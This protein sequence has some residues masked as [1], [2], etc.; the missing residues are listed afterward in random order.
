MSA[1]FKRTL[2]NTFRTG[3]LV[4]CMATLL[5]SCA[6]A[7][8]EKPKSVGVGV[9]SI[10]YAGKEVELIVV[11][12]LNKSNS[13]GGDALNPYGM[14]GTICC[15][16]IPAEWHS[17]YQ[18]IVKYSFYPDRTWHEQLV[19]VPPYP[20]GIAGEIWLAMHVDGRA[21]AVVSNFDPSRSE[22]PGRVKGPPVPSES[23]IEK[24]RA[25][26]LNTQKG[27]LAAMEKGLKDGTDELS[28]EQIDRLKKAIE[29]TKKRIQ[30]MEENMP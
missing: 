6:S 27:M 26:R 30:L 28:P 24:V 20:Q 25:D 14:G 15:F 5:V 11:D 7:Q 12:P 23:Y 29:N 8:S 4:V 22:W 16:S 1:R 19:D 2:R 13:S 17:G 3:G 21:E 10:N 9:R 18:V